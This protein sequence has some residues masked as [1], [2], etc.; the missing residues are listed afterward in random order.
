MSATEFDVFVSHATE[1]KP[2]VDPLAKALDDAGVRVWF[3]R[4]T[5]EWGDDSEVYDRPRV[6]TAALELSCS[7]RLFLARR[8]GRNMS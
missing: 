5:L 4:T 6:E 7:Q 2:Y 3:D 1:D 8:S